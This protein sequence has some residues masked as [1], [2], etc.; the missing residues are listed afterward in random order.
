MADCLCTYSDLPVPPQPVPVAVAQQF[1]PVQQPVAQVQYTYVQGLAPPPQVVL[2]PP[3]FATGVVTAP[4]PTMGVPPAQAPLADASVGT[5]CLPNPSLVVA[6]EAHAALPAMEQ[7][8]APPAAPG[9]AQ[10][11]ADRQVIEASATTPRLARRS[12]SRNC[13]IVA[14][15]TRNRCCHSAARGDAPV[16]P[17]PSPRE[18]CM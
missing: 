7:P 5:D 6:T 13:T 16:S 9:T 14:S 3:T 8:V 15:S 2:A 17:G 12:V 11:A 10:P 4:P 18:L 1:V